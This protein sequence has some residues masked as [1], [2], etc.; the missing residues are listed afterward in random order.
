MNKIGKFLE[1]LEEKSKT[2]EVW[3]GGGGHGQSPSGPGGDFKRII[4]APPSGGLKNWWNPRNHNDVISGKFGTFKNNYNDKTVFHRRKWFK[5]T[6]GDWEEKDTIFEVNVKSRDTI[7]MT[8]K[9][10][11]NNKPADVSFD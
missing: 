8:I 2:D 5:W 3:G 7:N 4:E 6:W 11:V 10:T 9:E 1:Y